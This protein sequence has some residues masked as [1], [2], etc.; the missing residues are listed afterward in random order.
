[1]RDELLSP[2]ERPQWLAR[3]GDG[4]RRGMPAQSHPLPLRFRPVV[5]LLTTA[6]VLSALWYWGRLPFYRAVI[7][8]TFFPEVE[9]TLAELYGYYYLAFSSIL[10]R[11]IIPLGIILLVF[12]DH[13]RNF[14]FRL[15]GTKSLAKIY[16]VL[17]AGML[18]LMVLASG[19]ASFQAKYPLYDYAHHSLWHLLVYEVAYVL[20][21][22]SGEAFWRGFLIFSLAP[23]FGLYSLLIMAIPYAMIHFGK[24]FPES[25][26]AIAAGVILGAIA[27]KH[28]SFWFGVALHASIGVG[29]D[30]LC[31]WRK[32]ELL[33]LFTG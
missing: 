23:V 18:P 2:A 30:L 28:R 9:P 19:M 4:L 5:A 17:L 31:L 3:L 8:P 20:V 27:L 25:M 22:L 1:M 14:G 21:F 6:V 26:G 12:R 29:M 33:T 16:V 32:G 7:Q 11:M 15:R 10:T 24:P 13:P